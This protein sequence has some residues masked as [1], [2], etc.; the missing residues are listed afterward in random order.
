MMGNGWTTVVGW[1]KQ[2]SIHINQPSPLGGMIYLGHSWNNPASCI[3]FFHD[4][5]Q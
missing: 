2:L 1:E 3:E 5:T 4:G